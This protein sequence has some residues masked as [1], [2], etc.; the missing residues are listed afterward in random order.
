MSEVKRDYE[1]GYGKPPAGRRFQK[2]QSGN[3]R[4]PRRKDLSA[5]L[6]AAL[7]EPVYTTIDGHRRKITKREAIIKQMVDKSAEADLRATKM[8]FD[9]LKEV[10]QKAG[11]APP[12]EPAALTAPDREVVELFVAR[13]R[14]Q[15]AAEAAEA[16]AEGASFETVAERPPQDEGLS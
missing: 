14:R 8:L 9:M 12:P 1:I 13:L 7:N 15:I 4:G 5:L 10:E 6:V 3:P 11:T 2:G 16:A